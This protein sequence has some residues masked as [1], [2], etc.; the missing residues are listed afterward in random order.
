MLG[1]TSGSS[2]AE[3]SVALHCAKCEAVYRIGYDA[4]ALTS[5]E[6]AGMMPSLNG[7][8]QSELMIGRI[9]TKDIELLQ[10]NRNSI[11][12]LGPLRGWTCMQC[13]HNNLWSPIPCSPVAVTEAKA[14]NQSACSPVAVTEAKAENQSACSPAAVT[15]AKAENQSACSPA[16]VTEAKAGNQSRWWVEPV[17][18]VGFVLVIYPFLYYFRAHGY[19]GEQ[20]WSFCLL[21]LGLMIVRAIQMLFA[22]GN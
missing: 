15:E 7:K 4:F 2:T 5:E 13:R 10:Q 19:Y 16:A 17:S 20:A 18:E 6:M 3:P 14:E 1:V 12:R 9:E 22:G 11:L 21:V 8:L